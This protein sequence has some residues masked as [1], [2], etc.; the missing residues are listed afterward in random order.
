MA[1]KSESKISGLGEVSIRAIDG[2]Y[3]RPESSS[4]YEDWGPMASETKDMQISRWLVELTDENGAVV[5][6]GDLSA[7]AVWYGPTLGSR[8]MNIGIS[9]VN[10][11]RGKGIG[12]IAQRLLAE[13]LH[14]QGNIRIES[15]L[16]SGRYSSQ[17][18]RA[19]GWI[20]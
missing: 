10:D 18:S 2:D 11:F 16:C 14:R 15:R 17:S 8:S 1:P 12:S 3:E 7:H 19:S 5:P 4:I 9:I 13:E 6:V 20:A